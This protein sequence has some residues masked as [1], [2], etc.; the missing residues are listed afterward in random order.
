MYDELL[1]KLHFVVFFV[2]FNMVYFSMFLGWETP[3]R[4]F[5][6]NPE[7][8]IYHQFGT[9]GAFV[10][11]LSFFIMFYNFAKSYVSGEPAGDN[12]WDYSRTAGGP[13]PRPRRSR[14]GR[15]VPRTPPASWSS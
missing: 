11:G 8:Q 7:F 12:P 4:V 3:R 2:S 9:I 10:L 13:S 15:T 6:Y 5:E 14:T 1:G